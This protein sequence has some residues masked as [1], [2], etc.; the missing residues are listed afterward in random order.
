[1]STSRDETPLAAPTAAK[2]KSNLWTRDSSLGSFFK[3]KVV[4]VIGASEKPG[5]V[6]RALLENLGTFSGTLYPVNAMRDEVLGKKAYRNIASVP[7]Q[8]DLAL[9]ATPAVT[10]PGIIRECVA[11]GVKAAIVISAGFKES[12]AVGTDLERQIL[13]STKGTA[14]RV[15]GPNCLGVMAPHINLNATFSKDMAK[16]GNVAFLTQSGALGTAIIDWSL[17]EK[18]GFSA[19]VSIGSMLDIGWGDLIRYLGDDPQTHSIMIYM[20]SVGNAPAFLA[21]VREVAPI[22]PIVVIKVGRT[23]AAA[24]AAASHTGAL[25]G[26]DEVLDAAFKRAG[27]LRVETIEEFFSMAK[28]LAKQPLPRGPRLS[29]VTNAG[30]PGV[31]ATDM[32]VECG[33][34]LAVPSPETLSELNKVLP[35]HWSHSNPIDIL[36]DADAARYAA[37]VAVAARDPGAD[38]VLVIL[39]PQAMTDP[40]ATADLMRTYAHMEGKPLL[41]SWMG[42]TRA[43]TGRVILTEAGIPMFDYPDEAARAFAN[44]WH[45]TES[46]LPRAQLEPPGEKPAPFAPEPDEARVADLIAAVR[47]RKGTLLTEYESKQVL[48]LYGIPTVETRL[49]TTVAEAIAAAES[50]N[51]PVVLKLHSDTITHKTDVGG[52]KLNIRDASEVRAAWTA[53][54]SAVKAKHGPGHFQ[55]VTVQ[56]MVMLK[57]CEL[58]LGS[59]LDPQFG[60]VLLFGAGGVLVDV[61]KDRALGLPPLDPYLARRLMEQTKIFKVLKGVRGRAS[62]DMAALDQILVRFSRLVAEQRWIKEID[63]NPLLASPERILALDARIVLHGP[64][65]RAEDIPALAATL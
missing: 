15:I 61:F 3:P 19:F 55:G 49:A 7:T 21:A 13:E 22:K 12:G 52:V 50:I 24:Q 39:T 26:S 53:I 57:G 44:M 30:G 47:R 54:E 1:M 6:G 60:P 11:A 27:V 40:I 20:E 18:V 41:T 37:A 32:L 46:R 4:A 65:V 56:P 48:S 58:I 2:L 29:I 64:E 33:G 17:K 5:G 23:D 34:Q 38:G 59:S 28:V 31:L 10:V 62:V 35:A 8:V 9:I 63:I 43:K 25:T 14:L 51:F 45:Y 16:S 36:G 42:G